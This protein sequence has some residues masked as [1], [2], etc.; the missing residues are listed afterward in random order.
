[1]IPTDNLRAAQRSALM[2]DDARVQ[3]FY[4]DECRLGWAYTRGPFKGYHRHAYESLPGDHLLREHMSRD[5]EEPAW[6]VY[7][8]YPPGVQWT[9]GPPMPARWVKQAGFESEDRS[10]L[11]RNDCTMPPIE[12]SLAK[13]LALQMDAITSRR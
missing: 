13:E 7:F 9:D 6:D 10:I 2:F 12:N 4:D 8:F 5:R 1:M 3:Q 11:W